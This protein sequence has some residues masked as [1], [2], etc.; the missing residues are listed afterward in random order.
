[1]ESKFFF[2]KVK[3][4]NEVNKTIEVVGST[5]EL[6]RDGER[7]LPSA[8]LT[9]IDSFK[10]NPVILA[11]HQHR[12]ESGSSSVIGSAIPE[13]IAI[14]KTDVSFT[15]RFADT[16]LGNEYWQLYK[17][18]HMRAF[19]VGFIPLKWKDEDGTRIYSE[20]EP[21]EFSAVAVPSNR[22]ALA[23][24]KGYFDAEETKDA[25]AAV[26]EQLADLKQFIE[27]KF[28]DT[29]AMIC[30]N[31]GGLADAL[32][33]GKSELPDHGGEEQKLSEQNDRIKNAFNKVT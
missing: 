23:R 13:S 14:N 18:K 2:A 10:S 33:G 8:F 20:I 30:A 25:I 6:D 21:L 5:S 11:G 31:S 17:D 3:S 16:K 1:M 27:Q 26:K 24:A 22:G 4:I 28:T 19:S 29:D 7:I 9:H 32:L 15:M 12:L